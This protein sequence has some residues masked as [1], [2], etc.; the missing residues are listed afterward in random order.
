MGSLLIIF[1][2]ILAVAVF[3]ICEISI[4]RNDDYELFEE[5]A[6]GLFE[7]YGILIHDE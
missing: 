7:F 4:F 6:D 1:F 5:F 3:I 2:T